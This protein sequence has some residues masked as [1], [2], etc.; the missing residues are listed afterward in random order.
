MWIIQIQDWL[1]SLI[2]IQVAFM[3]FCSVLTNT[4]TR[5]K[6][7]NVC[8]LWDLWDF[9]VCLLSSF[10]F[11]CCFCFCKPYWTFVISCYFFPLLSLSL[12]R[13]LLF[14]ALFLFLFYLCVSLLYFFFIYNCSIKLFCFFILKQPKS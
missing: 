14:Y 3:C 9:P 8:F 1:R 10:L 12:L 13:C 11:F 5:N 4:L 6:D 7:T 2:E